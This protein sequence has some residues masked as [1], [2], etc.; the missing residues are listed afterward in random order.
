MNPDIWPYVKQKGLQFRNAGYTFLQEGPLKQG[1]KFSH[2]TTCAAGNAGDTVLSQCV[3]TFFQSEMQIAKWDIIPVTNAVNDHTVRE[4]NTTQAVVVGGGGLFLPDTNA[5]RISGWQW[6]VSAEQLH[7]IHKPLFV[8]SVGYNYFRG[9]QASELFRTNLCELVK[10]AEFFG[11]RNHGSVKAVQALLPDN[12][13]EKVVFQPCTTTL[14]RK[15]Y[16]ALPPKEKTGT[17][18]VN[19]A[20]DRPERRFGENREK[21]LNQVARSVREIADEGCKIVY[22]AHMKADFQFLKYLNAACVPFQ[23]VDLTN[24]L[25]Q[26]VFRFYNS[27]D[28]VIGMRGHAQMIPFGL[29]CGILSLGSHDKMRW[30]LEDIEEPGLYV[31]LNADADRLSERILKAFHA[32]YGNDREETM[33][34]L[35]AKQEM[36]YRISTQNAEKIRACL[37]NASVL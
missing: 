32:Q 1:P 6:A 29:N 3:R 27:M 16:P 37:P 15:L 28:V 8:F 24:A 5:N 13:K 20:F 33:R 36:L 10:K 9:Q 4:I 26:K 18:A 30:F 19:L 11:L 31:D 21:I 7:E 12:L 23:I 17:V 14:I 22:A 2:I 35:A 34:R 25:P